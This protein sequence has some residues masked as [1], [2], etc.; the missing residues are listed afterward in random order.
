MERP[1]TT[2]RRRR[3][4]QLVSEAAQ[5]T[6]VGRAIGPRAHRPYEGRRR[7]ARIRR[8]RRRGFAERGLTEVDAVILEHGR[9]VPL[10][11]ECTIER[12][13]YGPGCTG[14]G[15]AR[16]GSEA[17]TSGNSPL[18]YTLSRLVLPQAPSPTTT[19]CVRASQLCSVGRVG[20]VAARRKGGPCGQAARRGGVSARVGRREGRGGRA[21]R[22]RLL[23]A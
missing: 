10:H 19:T 23:P 15:G 6:A 18:T 21:G 13:S 9:L 12:V 20:E 2:A 3:G 8:R 1:S 7:P 14:S 5:T 16:R 11:G 22:A 17:R 4:R